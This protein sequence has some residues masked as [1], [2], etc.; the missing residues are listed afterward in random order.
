MQAALGI[1]QIK[2]IEKRN[3]EKEILK[4]ITKFLKDMKLPLRL[5]QR[6]KM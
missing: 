5:Q 3:K 2:N 6:E 4:T 1:S